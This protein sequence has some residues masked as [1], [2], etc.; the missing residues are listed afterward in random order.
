MRGK[1]YPCLLGRNGIG[2]NKR[3][4]DMKTP[5]GRFH[6][7]YALYRPDRISPRSGLLP[8]RAI[9]KKDGWCDA[10]NNPNY[11]RPVTLP[12][13]ASHEVLQREDG[14]YDILVVMDHNFSRRAR[15][16]GSAVFLHLTANKDH[17]AGCVAV[18]KKT[19]LYL[20]PLLSQETILQI[21]P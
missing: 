2:V 3:E 16:R 12:F 10:A 18:S 6:L 13:G 1:A 17:T 19:M 9:G 21:L 15:G 5:A 14:L 7:L 8:I 4:G 11:N 20:L